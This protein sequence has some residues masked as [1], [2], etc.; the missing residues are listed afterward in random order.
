MPI[1]GKV[2]MVSIAL[3]AYGIQGFLSFILLII[4][5]KMEISISLCMFVALPSACC[6]VSIRPCVYTHGTV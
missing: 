6:V 4:Y 3:S 1:C 2:I 5:A